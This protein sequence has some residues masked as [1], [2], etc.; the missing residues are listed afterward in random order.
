[1]AGA[2]SQ[3][4]LFDSKPRLAAMEGKPIPPEVIGG[5]RY[6]FIRPDAAVLG[7]RYAF[8]RHGRCGAELSEM[9]PHL[10]GV[11]DDIAIVK[12]CRTD[13]F[14]HAPAQIF[15]NCGFAQPGRPSI[16]SWVTY[17]LGSESEDLPAFVVMST[18]KGISGGAANWSSGLISP[19]S[20]HCLV[21]ETFCIIVGVDNLI[22]QVGKTCIFENV[23][24][25]SAVIVELNGDSG[26]A[27]WVVVV[28]CLH[29]EGGYRLVKSNLHCV[30]R[31][32]VGLV[33]EQDAPLRACACKKMRV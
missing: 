27:T 22:S 24:D 12:S 14:N 7:P 10:A 19:H 13:Q 17:G 9:L 30:T 11:V 2:P 23:I 25:I 18:G 4:E 21:S 8:S 28:P 20:L 33:L 32:L 5:A 15:M 1:M 6:A 16:G 3:L 26:V 31:H 29:D